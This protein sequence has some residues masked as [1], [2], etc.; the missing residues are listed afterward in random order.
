MAN[1]NL[2][3]L[4]KRQISEV[5]WGEGVGVGADDDYKSSTEKSLFRVGARFVAGNTHFKEIL[6]KS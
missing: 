2:I 1:F 6:I 3:L 4:R 5:F